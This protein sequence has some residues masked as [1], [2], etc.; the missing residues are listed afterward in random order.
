MAK[1]N[2]IKALCVLHGKSHQ[3]CVFN[4]YAVVGNRYRASLLHTADC[5]KFFPF[6]TLCNCADGVDFTEVHL[7]RPPEGVFNEDI[8]RLCEE[9]GY[10]IV[11]WSVDTRDWAH[12]PIDQIC[13]NIRENVKNGSIILMHDFIGKNSP[14]SNSGILFFNTL[15]DENASCHLAFGKAYP[16]TIK[17]GNDLTAEQLLE[18]CANDSIQHVDFM[19]GTKDLSIT[20][21]TEDGRSVEIFKDGEWA[22]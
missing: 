17:N 19:I 2:H 15:F 20:A 9:K 1:T 3:S 21:L 22:F 5:G 11:M 14:I 6:A 4:G 18:T 10:T 16:T 13:Q 12:T 8:K 7:F